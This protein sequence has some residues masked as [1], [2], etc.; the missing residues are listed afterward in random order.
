MVVYA[1]YYGQPRSG[2]E[3]QSDELGRI[4]LGHIDAELPAQ[5]GLV[6]LDASTL[7]TNRINWVTDVSVNVNVWSTRHRS[8][9]NILSCDFIDG[10]L[11]ELLH[12]P[13]KLQCSLISEHHPS[14]HIGE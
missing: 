14:M 4:D 9:N 3:Q 13:T 7:N 8:D 11:T 5:G 12:A 6:R 1:A 2:Y 10:P